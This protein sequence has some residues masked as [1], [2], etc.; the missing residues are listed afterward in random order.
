[1]EHVK[2]QMSTVKAKSLVFI[3]GQIGVMQVSASS[4]VEGAGKDGIVMGDRSL[5][6][7]TNRLGV[8][9]T[10][11]TYRLPASAPAHASRGSWV[12]AK[13]RNETGR[14]HLRCRKWKLISLR[15]VPAQC[16]GCGSGR[17]S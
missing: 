12:E 13:T 1:M 7:P 6:L 17:V 2:C 14:V 5:S 16:L 11:C 15:S 9:V 8:E 10:F 4:V 3:E